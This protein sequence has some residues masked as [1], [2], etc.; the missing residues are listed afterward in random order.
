MRQKLLTAI[1][2]GETPDLAR[3]DIVRVPEFADL[4]G[5]AKVDEMPDFATYTAVLP[6]RSRPTIYKGNYYGLP[7]DTNTRLLFYNSR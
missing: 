6:A 3:A 1:A 2:G 7:L 5:L 4:G